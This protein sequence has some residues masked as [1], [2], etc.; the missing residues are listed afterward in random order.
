MEL[1]KGPKNR[2]CKNTTIV[3]VSVYK[4]SIDILSYMKLVEL[5][6][7]PCVSFRDDFRMNQFRML[8]N[9]KPQLELSFKKNALGKINT[10]YEFS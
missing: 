7:S 4:T 8:K 3:Q 9:R 2:S 5:N 6:I 1:C 10:T